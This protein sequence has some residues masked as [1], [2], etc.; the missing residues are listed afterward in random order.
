M[1]FNLLFIMKKFRHKTLWWIAQERIDNKYRVFV[2]KNGLEMDVVDWIPKELIENSQDREEFVEKDWIGDILLEYNK[3]SF[4]NC[5]R[6]RK[7]I[8]KHA[9]KVKKFTEEEVQVWNEMNFR[10]CPDT[11]CDFLRVNWLLEE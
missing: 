4:L 8:E 2:W 5:E 6:M 9:P 1:F 3:D 7:I 10:M 11:I